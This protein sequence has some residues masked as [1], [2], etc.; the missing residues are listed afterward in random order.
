MELYPAPKLR[1][2]TSPRFKLMRGMKEASMKHLKC[3]AFTEKRNV[4]PYHRDSK[5]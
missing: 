5:L 3:R 4:T 1:S 2:L